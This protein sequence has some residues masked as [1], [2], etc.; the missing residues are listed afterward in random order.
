MR[1]PLLNEHLSVHVKRM[2]ILTA[3]RPLPE[4]GAEVLLPTREHARALESV[5]LK[6][7]R[8]ILRCPPWTNSDVTRADMGLQLLAFRRDI[9]KL[10]WQHRLPFG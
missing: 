7:A 2:L 4:Y 6:A 8:M 9:A 1:K 3:S 10:K 5:Q